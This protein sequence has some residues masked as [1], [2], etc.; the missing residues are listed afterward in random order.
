MAKFEKIE[1]DISSIEQSL[2]KSLKEALTQQSEQLL[3][4]FE[5]LLK[6]SPGTKDLMRDRSRPPTSLH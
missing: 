1:T 2:K 4:T 5:S 3:S 6:K